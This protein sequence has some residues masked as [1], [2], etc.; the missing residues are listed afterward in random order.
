MSMLKYICLTI[1]LSTYKKSK[2]KELKKKFTKNYNHN[3]NE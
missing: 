3:K 2:N 1:D